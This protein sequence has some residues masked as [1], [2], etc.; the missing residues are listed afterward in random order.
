MGKKAQS[1][2]FAYKDDDP[3]MGQ[4]LKKEAQLR[5]DEIKQ[6]IKSQMRRQSKSPNKKSKKE[7][8]LEHSLRTEIGQAVRG[9]QHM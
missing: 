5:K 8:K 1:R 7:V 6:E 9:M 2:L 4:K 3:K